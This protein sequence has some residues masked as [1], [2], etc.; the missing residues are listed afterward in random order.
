L[1]AI[2]KKEFVKYCLAFLFHFHFD[3][4]LWDVMSD[5][6]IPYR[7]RARKPMALDA[8]HSRVPVCQQSGAFLALKFGPEGVWNQAGMARKSVPL[9]CGEQDFEDF[10]TSAGQ[11]AP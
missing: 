4:L 1:P 6:F 3:K 5:P 7:H 10:R 11:N 9:I 8:S 2:L